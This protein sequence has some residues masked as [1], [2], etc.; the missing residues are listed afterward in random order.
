MFKSENEKN[1]NPKFPKQLKEPDISMKK[2]GFYFCHI[3]HY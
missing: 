1:I 2:N 3:T